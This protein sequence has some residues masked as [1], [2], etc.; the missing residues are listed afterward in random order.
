MLTLL[1]PQHE[2]PAASGHV[3]DGRLYGRGA[4]DAKGPPAAF[5]SA[6]ARIAASGRPPERT[7]VLAG[8]I[9]EEHRYRGVTHLLGPDGETDTTG[10]GSDRSAARCA[11]AVVGEPTSLALVVA[12]KG[13]MRCRIVATG[14]SGHSSLPEGRVN[15]V[16]TA[17]RRRLRPPRAGRGN[18]R[19]FLRRGRPCPDCPWA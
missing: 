11:G 14:P 13:V 16:E 5:L 15:P 1:L 18:R 9:D 7:V 6:L 8:V 10:D 3:R 4:C 2:F 19:R 12:H 17:T